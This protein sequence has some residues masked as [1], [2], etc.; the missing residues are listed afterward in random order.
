[1]RTYLFTP[2]CALMTEFCGLGMLNVLHRV[3]RKGLFDAACSAK[4]LS[5]T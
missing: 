5:P 4:R 2:F 3:L 1:M